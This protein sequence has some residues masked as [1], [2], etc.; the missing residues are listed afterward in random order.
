MLKTARR[1]GQESVG[2]FPSTQKPSVNHL[3]CLSYCMGENYGVISTFK[4]TKRCKRS[5]CK[6][7]T[8]STGGRKRGALTVV[9][10]FC[11]GCCFFFFFKGIHCVSIS[12]PPDPK[13]D[14]AVLTSEAPD[15]AL[16]ENRLRVRLPLPR[17]QVQSCDNMR[18]QQD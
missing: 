2:N 3:Y 9:T 10:H 6:K 18:G 7:L 11:H 8:L 12:D 1:E 4:A 14:A 16:C 15:A 17:A 13:Q 5:T